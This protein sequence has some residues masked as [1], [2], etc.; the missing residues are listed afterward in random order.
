M[1]S[2][3]FLAIG[4]II[5]TVAY[6]QS[7]DRNQPTTPAI[8]VSQKIAEE[9]HFTKLNL[10]E[11]S[12]KD[13]V[14]F[15]GE[16]SKLKVHYIA[17]KDNIDKVTLKLSNVPAYAAFYYV[18]NATHLK[19]VYKDDGVYFTPKAAEQGAAANP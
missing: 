7:I 9:Y 3:L 5:L 17:P 10:E 1:K 16:K 18:A 19:V 14:D 11:V 4:T 6:A 2:P 8:P 12:A 15:I 13:A